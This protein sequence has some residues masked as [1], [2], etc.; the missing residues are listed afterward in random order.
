M[1]K[2]IIGFVPKKSVVNHFRTK[3]MIGEITEMTKYS[4][5]ATFETSQGTINL[6]YPRVE[7]EPFLV[8]ETPVRIHGLTFFEFSKELIGFDVYSTHGFKREKYE[9]FWTEVKVNVILSSK[10]GYIC[11]RR[12][13]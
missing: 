2:Q 5:S 8:P 10:Y 9:L 4:V 1:N 11:K 3:N 12:I 13:D 6:A 7:A